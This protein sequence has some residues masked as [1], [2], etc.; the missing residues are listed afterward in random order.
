VALATLCLAML[1]G[2]ANAS[3]VVIRSQ[4]EAFGPDGTPASSFGAGALRD[5]AFNQATRG[6]Y[7]IDQGTPG[8]Y[9]FDVSA[10][11]AHTPL[12]GFSPLGTVATGGDPGLAV[13]DTALP[14][15]GNV[16]FVSEAFGTRKVY[17]F[18]S[19]GAPLGGNFPI[20]PAITPGAPFGSPTDVCGAAVDSAGNLWVPNYNTKSILEYNSA[21]VYQATVSTAAQGFF[22]CAV[23]FDSN[24]DMYVTN[25]GDSSSATYKYTAASGYTAATLIGASSVRGN[26]VDRSTHHVFLLSGAGIVNE[27]DSAG[28]FVSTTSGKDSTGDTVIPTPAGIKGASFMGVAV[29]SANDRLYVSEF[30]SGKILAFGP[31]LTY[32]DLTLGAASGV[33]STSATINGTI[34]AQG[35]PLSDCHV[36]YV[37]AF[38]AAGF[39]D[40]SSGGSAPCSPAAGSIPTDSAIHPVTATLSGLTPNAP[41]R[42]RLVAANANGP[43]ATPEAKLET[44][45]PPLVETTG[46]PVRTT[47]TARLDARVDPA[48][49]SA[50]YHFEYGDQGPCDANPC[51]STEAHPAGSGTEFELVSQQV[52]GLQPGATYHYRVIADNGDPAGASFGEDMTVT[53]LASEPV[54]SHGHLPGPP[55]SDRAWELASAPDTGGNPVGLSLGAER[56]SIA[57]AGNRVTYG[58]AGGTPDSETGTAATMLFAERTASG[59]Q[60]KRILPSRQEATESVWTSPGGP[61]DLS[62]MISLNRPFSIAGGLTFWRFTPN[63]PAQKLEGSAKSLEE[64]SLL[65]VSENS[66]P[67]VVAS[68]W[69]AW[70]PAH[71]VPPNAYNIYDI[72]AGAPRIIGLLPDGAVP[73]C[74]VSGP[75]NT[76]DRVAH[77]ASADGSLAFFEVQSNSNCAGP[78][79]LYVRDIGAEATALI[80]TP[81]ASGPECRATFLKSTPDAAFFFT[82]SRLVAEDTEPASCNEDS[83]DVYR[84][85]LGDGSLDCV[86]C[87]VPGVQAAMSGSESTNPA[88]GISADGSRVYFRSANRLLP[89]A[90]AKGGIYRVDVA[91]GDLAYVGFT[92]GTIGS[93]RNANLSSDGSVAVFESSRPSMDALGGQ[94][95][96]GTRQYYR[97][98]DSDRSLI[99]VSCPA[100]GSAPRGQVPEG[101]DGSGRGAN[102]GRLDAAGDVFAFATPTALVA[103]DQNTAGAGQDPEAGQDVYEWRNGRLLLVS[104]GLADWP[105]NP[106]SV[107]GIT[108]SG[109]DI[110]FLEAAQLT[111]DALDGYSRLYD[112]RIG[113][114][115]EF[116]PPPKPCPLEV[117]QGIP[118]G[119]PEEQAPGTATIA[120][121]GNAAAQKKQHKAKKRHQ[122]KRHKKHAKK[123]HRKA[124][125]N[126][127]AGR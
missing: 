46:S 79:Q 37:N 67:T 44:A 74:S 104:D 9:G 115:F 109:N 116:P 21:G 69:G 10:P 90:A 89:G 103:A 92:G 111:H 95:N 54:L 77:A 93:M 7:A 86:T 80:S 118:K 68:L 122:K 16:Y 61:R 4:V 31:A 123:A 100:D 99:C 120:G 58:V 124:N 85:G 113:G 59:W 57:D 65:A 94:Q 52:E 30:A 71:P 20:D 34:S 107:I 6:L 22:P 96:A 17:G 121:V 56:F 23:A 126:R 70:D 47:T 32:P 29:D 55:G 5:L 49:S 28:N 3:A 84:Y 14:S 127:G 117:C 25:G 97:Y 106:P 39:D 88:V 26:A 87:V 50:T 36:E 63:S 81:P 98:D 78:A 2:A 48:G 41:Y 15:S 40:L 11:P 102:L 19:S 42:F 105:S 66:E 45:G 27:Y 35:V 76:I 112:A 91:S 53:T 13:D 8:V 43:I 18:D 125:S 114:G 101:F 64:G 75:V 33:Q 108:P 73:P 1:L 60:T 24:D 51:T 62:E 38:K 83:G 72:G 82:Q 119:A 110:F 12:A